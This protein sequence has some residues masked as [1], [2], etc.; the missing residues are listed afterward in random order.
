MITMLQA[1][2]AAKSEIARLS[3]EQKN[4]ALLAM[5]DALIA[6]QAEILTANAADLEQA[7]DTISPVMLD[8]LRL[9]EERIAGM[10]KGIREV[11]ELPDPVGR[12]LSEYVRPDE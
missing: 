6:R 8:R 7:K 10:A 3:T 2:K 5:A 4:N 11:A 9:T 12:Q 1:A